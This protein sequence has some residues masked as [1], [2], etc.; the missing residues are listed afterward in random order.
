MTENTEYYQNHP[1]FVPTDGHILSHGRSEQ[2]KHAWD[3][4]DDSAKHEMNDG[5]SDII[6]TSGANVRDIDAIDLSMLANNGK[7]SHRDYLDEFG[8]QS[9][10]DLYA[11]QGVNGRYI[12]IS[13]FNYYLFLHIIPHTL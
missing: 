3:H 10:V 12:H 8:F 2:L 4:D 1:H 11:N 5:D 13:C 9:G 6:L 7:D